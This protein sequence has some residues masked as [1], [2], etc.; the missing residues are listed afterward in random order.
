MTAVPNNEE[1]E[2]QNEYRKDELDKLQDVASIPYE[3]PFNA[4][5]N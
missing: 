3:I 4:P 5:V 2:P 1:A